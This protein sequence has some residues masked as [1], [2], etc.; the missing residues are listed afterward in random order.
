LEQPPL[1]HVF[2][3]PLDHRSDSF[4]SML[5]LA[6]GIWSCA[7]IERLSR[8]SYGLH[9]NHAGERAG[10]YRNNLRCRHL[11]WTSQ[12]AVPAKLLYFFKLE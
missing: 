8:D 11:V 4:K 6:C 1:A 7:M 2:A 9:F 5:Q 10:C 3:Y 12:V